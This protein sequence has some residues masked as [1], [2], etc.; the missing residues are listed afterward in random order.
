MAGGI[1]Y[2]QS[3]KEK[4][5]PKPGEITTDETVD[6]KTYRNEEL[7]LIFKYPN[8]WIEITEYTDIPYIN[9][10]YSD[11]YS[12]IQ[13]LYPE[14]G[15]IG[16]FIIDYSVYNDLPDN[17]TEEELDPIEPGR[18][19]TKQDVDNIRTY[20]ESGGKDMSMVEGILLLQKPKIINIGS[21]KKVKAIIDQGGLFVGS[22]FYKRAIMLK[23]K[24]VIFLLMTFRGGL[25]YNYKL[26][27][28]EDYVMKITENQQIDLPTQKLLT[29]FDQ[30][31]STF[32]FIE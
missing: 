8:K 10:P 26:E 30:I 22:G 32:K 27:E 23:E 11:E 19:L 18:P 3:Q 24:D 13:L 6:W 7:G 14:T 4:E 9:I 12:G 1:W 15:L 31:L 5:G 29:T 25:D 21:N 17:L 2:W 28:L 16:Q 20:I